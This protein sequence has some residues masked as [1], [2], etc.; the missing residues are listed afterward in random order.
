MGAVIASTTSGDSNGKFV[1]GPE[2]YMASLPSGIPH[3]ALEPYLDSI[4]AHK[5]DFVMCSLIHPHTSSCWGGMANAFY[6]EWFRAMSMY[7]PLNAV[8]DTMC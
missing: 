8:N 5:H 1:K 3:T 6:L 2:G 4:S 7:A